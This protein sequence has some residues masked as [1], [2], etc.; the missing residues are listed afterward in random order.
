MQGTAIYGQTAWWRSISLRIH[1]VLQCLYASHLTGVNWQ[2]LSWVATSWYCRTC[3]HPI[4]WCLHLN[5]IFYSF[6]STSFLTLRNFGFSHC[7]GHI[8]VSLWNFSRHLW[9]NRLL[10]DLHSTGST[11]MAWQR[12]QRNSGFSWSFVSRFWEFKDIEILL[13]DIYC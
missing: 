2:S 7:I 12:E 1:F 6:F 13:T 11:N 4:A 8:P 3:V 5:C 10:Q 9:W